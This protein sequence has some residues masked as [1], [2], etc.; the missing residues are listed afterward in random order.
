MNRFQLA[1]PQPTESLSVSDSSVVAHD[2]QASTPHA[3][4]GPLHYE[5]GYAYPLIVWLHGAGDDERQ[6]QRIMPL[7]SMRNYV[8]VG[9]RGSRIDEGVSHAYCWQQ[10]EQDIALAEQRVLECVELASR[11]FN[12]CSDRVFIGGYDC[13]GTMAFRVGL[14]HPH[15]FAGVFSI[16]GPFPSGLTPLV[17]V[18][19]ARH[20]PLLIA[21]G[22]SA[23]KYPLARICR[24]LRLLHSAG[25]MVNL[26][27]YP[28][29]DELTTQMLHDLDAWVMDQI[30]GVPANDGEHSIHSDE[31]N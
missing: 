17:N 2:N 20:L 16:G 24:E 27:Q 6:L 19:Q 13:G 14:N 18:S 28:C 10:S 12:I 29:G 8:A 23:E 11:R 9:P 3:L 31:L 30:A 22:R 1:C 5:A 25:F 26:R 15:R 4:F 21:Q 7:I